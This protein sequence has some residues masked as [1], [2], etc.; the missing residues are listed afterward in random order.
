[1]ND[2][3]WAFE[4]WSM[5]KQDEERFKEMEAM[6]EVVEGRVARALGID[7]MP[8]EDSETHLL[9]RPERGEY[10]PFLIAAGRE[11]FVKMLL[12]K[13]QEFATQ[14]EVRSQM[15]SG[16]GVQDGAEEMSPEEL[17]KF[18]QGDAESG[19]TPEELKK[20]MSWGSKTNQLL[21]ENLV[22]AKEDV[23][24]ADPLEQKSART[25]GKARRDLMQQFQPPAGDL[26][27]VKLVSDSPPDE[28]PVQQDRI[29]I[30]L[31][32]V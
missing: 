16:A 32:D 17:E 2:T 13:R 23:D 12:E 19:N 6:V 7:L 21:L 28:T 3:Q 1:M 8:I 29:K 27:S 24:Q 26:M 30:V 14:E 4:L 22:L 10:V 9:R 15:A 20:L 18:M 5:N 31:K 25:I 11:D